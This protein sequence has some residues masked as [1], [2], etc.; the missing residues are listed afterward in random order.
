MNTTI[1]NYL[2][3]T[4]KH[5]FI[6]AALLCTTLA[7]TACSDDETA[8]EEAPAELTTP[9]NYV[10]SAKVSSGSGDVNYILTA[11]SIDGGEVTTQNNGLEAAT[12][13][14]WVFYKDKY[15]YR[16][17]YNQGESG[18]TESYCRNA[19]GNVVKRD[20]EYTIKNRFTT[21]GICGNSI[22]TA[23]SVDMTAP[24]GVNSKPKGIGLTYL[25]VVKETTSSAVINA[26]DVLGTGEYVTFSGLLETNGKIYTAVIPLGV[27]A[28]GVE[29]NY[30]KILYPDLIATSS[31]GT[32][33]GAVTAGTISGTQRPDEAWVAIYNDDRFEAPTLIKT[34]KI[35]YA[36]GRMRSQYYQTIWAADNGDIYVFSPNY[37]RTASDARQQSSLPSGVVRIKAGAKEFDNDY[38]VNIEALAGAP[39][40]RCWHITGSCF[41]LQL[42][43]KGF[44]INGTGATR[45]AVFDAETRSLKTV[46]GLPA[47]DVLAS[48][49]KIPY[50]ENGY[51]YIG[52]VTTDGSQPA[53]YRIDPATAAATKGLVVDSSTEI[54]AI[55]VL[56]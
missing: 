32:G 5:L 4:E 38:Y 6:G 41:L 21:F 11:E 45:L 20:L 37:S 48:F 3:M 49:S 22:I 42:Y 44:N 40:Y 31:S 28:Y 15:L 29:T 24:E 23:A 35:S 43:T 8:G 36:C 33:S 55:G 9:G 53:I 50:T 56:N 30:G 1:K 52:V 47:E 17:Q 26:E 46:S 19:N 16:L 51:A 39:L 10:L 14:E 12:G 25:D 54:N 7:L 18:T 34:D 2:N 13:T 27:S